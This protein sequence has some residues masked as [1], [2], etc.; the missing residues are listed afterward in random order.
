MQIYGVKPLSQHFEKEMYQY[1]NI[2]W[3]MKRRPTYVS[4]SP[5]AL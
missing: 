5:Q 4:V 3:L 1:V 2:I